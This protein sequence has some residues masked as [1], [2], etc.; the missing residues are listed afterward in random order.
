MTNEYSAGY[1][2]GYSGQNPLAEDTDDEYW[3]GY[4][5]GREDREID[6]SRAGYYSE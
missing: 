3:R 2:D 6:R 1:S 5:Q 4:G